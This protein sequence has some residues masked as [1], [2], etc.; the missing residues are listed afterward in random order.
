MIKLSQ[1]SLVA[2]FSATIIFH[3]LILTGLIPFA[4]VWGGRLTDESSM[5]AFESVSLLLNFY[6]LFVVMA[7]SQYLKI[8]IPSKIVT[9]TL[10]IMAA[11]FGLNTVGNL[12]S[13]NSLE[14]MIFTPITFLIFLFVVI[15]LWKKERS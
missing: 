14:R 1:A 3:L 8:R 11:I 7:K 10:W 6:F 9:A 12:L 13:N 4:I 15:L 2:I 5:Y